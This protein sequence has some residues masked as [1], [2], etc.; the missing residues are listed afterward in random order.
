MKPA[1]PVA[2]RHGH[3]LL[4]SALAVVLVQGCIGVGDTSYE[5]PAFSIYGAS[6]EAPPRE[7]STAIP[8]K[9]LTMSREWGN[10]LPKYDVVLNDLQPEETRSI[11]NSDVAEVQ[12]TPKKTLLAEGEA[13]RSK[14][15]GMA[16]IG[17][18]PIRSGSA[19]KYATGRKFVFWHDD[20]PV[21]YWLDQHGKRVQVNE[22]DKQSIQGA[23]A[24]WRELNG[25]RSSSKLAFDAKDSA[26]RFWVN[27]PWKAS[28]SLQIDSKKIRYDEV[29]ISVILDPSAID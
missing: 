3:S 24:G 13:T 16:F 29:S 28:E 19:K 10:H 1:P 7:N 2:K 6:A 5:I 15:I 14:L 23:L 17:F 27:L 25:P 22:L 9:L 26:A 4:I 21:V 18:I 8:F 20:W 11:T 12:L